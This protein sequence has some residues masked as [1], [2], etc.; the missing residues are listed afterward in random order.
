MFYFV[1]ERENLR[2]VGC[3]KYYKVIFVVRT[4]L[5]LLNI[6]FILFQ[7]KFVFHVCV[8]EF[9]CIWIFEFEYYVGET[10]VSVF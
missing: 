3:S 4:I 6:M 10:F 1:D 7:V 2:L 9:N 5:L 8:F